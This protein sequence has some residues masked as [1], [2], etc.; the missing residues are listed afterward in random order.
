MVERIVGRHLIIPD[1]LAGFRPDRRYCVGVEIIA[2]AI[3]R[4]PGRGIADPPEDQIEF[5]IVRTSGPGTATLCSLRVF[6]PGIGAGLT[7]QRD[8]E[9]PPQAL[10]GLGIVAVEEPADPVLGAG[11]S[12]NHNSI[13][14]K[15]GPSS[16]DAKFRISETRAP[17]LLASLLIERNHACIESHTEDP[18]LVERGTAVDDPAADHPGRLGRVLDHRLP[19]FLAGERI[20]GH[21]LVL[22]GDIDH[23]LFDKRLRFLSVTVRHAVGPRRHAPPDGVAV[24]LL[25]RTKTLLG[26]THPI[27]DYLVSALSGVAQILIALG[28]CRCR[29]NYAEHTCENNPPHPAPPW[30]WLRSA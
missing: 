22:V 14:D 10:A 16:R 7:R 15:R 30:T 25:Q 3:E 26:K 21:R 9:M 28:K 24:D 13:R 4:V 27:G 11:G 20:N 18:A 6:G 8:G 19:D 29:Q 1:H 17:D 12:D 2:L 5:R 23:A